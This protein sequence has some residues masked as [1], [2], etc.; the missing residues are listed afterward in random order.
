MIIISVLAENMLKYA[1]LELRDLPEAG[2]IAISGPNESGK[3]AIGEIICFALFGRTFSC[4]PDELEKIIRWGQPRCS[5]ELSFSTADGEGYK[6]ARFLDNEGNRSA[7]L[8]RIGLMDDSIISGVEAV[9]EALCRLVGYDFDEFI[10]SFYLAQREITTPHPHSQAVKAMAGLAALEA[11]GRDIKRETDEDRMAIADIKSRMAAMDAELEALDIQKDHLRELE[12]QYSALEEEQHRAERQARELESALKAWEENMPRLAAARR[13]RRSIGI[14]CGLLTVGVIGSAFA[15][16]A[17]G[18]QGQPGGFPWGML[19]GLLGF[20]WL[21]ALGGLAIMRGRVEGLGNAATVLA[22]RLGAAGEGIA[23]YE[24]GLDEARGIAD[25]ELGRIHEQ[26]QVRQ[27][28]MARLDAAVN[29]EKERLQ[30]AA[31]LLRRRSAAAKKIAEHRR[32]I[33][34]RELAEGLLGGAGKHMSRRF[35]RDLRELAG[36]TLPLFTEGRYEHLKVDDDLNIRVFSNEKRDYM[37]L[38]EISSGTQRQIML[39]VRLALSQQLIDS[40]ETG[41]QFIF[42]DEPFAFFDHER[43][44]NSLAMLPQLSDDIAQIWVV[45]QEFPPGSRL[46]RHIEC[47]RGFSH[48]PANAA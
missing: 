26:S 44:C 8:S 32:R 16:W 35:N 13:S 41:E 42:L 4:G 18:S 19:C 24:T 30:N 22:A 5:V 31:D 46:D 40:T 33:A 1:R 37:A 48:L 6:I 9:D 34:V 23:D 47:S 21:I 39:A 43:T 45:A 27:E 7:C 2:V 29:A 12:A 25:C 3:S 38:H 10:E 36:R 15:A 17:P 11:V 28:E 14:L 20:M